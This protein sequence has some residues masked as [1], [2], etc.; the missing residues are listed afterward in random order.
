MQPGIDRRTLLRLGGYGV[1]SAAA[2]HVLAACGGGNGHRAAPRAIPPSTSEPRPATTVTDPSMPWWLRG[3]FGPVAREVEA[4]DLAVDGALPR[5]LSGLYVHNGSNP[6][7]G[8]SP[9]W[10][11]GDGMVH[12]VLLADGK[13]SWYRNRYVQTTLLAAGG[14]LTAKGAPGGAS[15]L[16]NVSLV[17]HAGKLLSL[18][19]VG[20]PYELRPR[21]LST[22]GVYDFDGKLEGN[23][24][25]HPKIDP[26]TQQMHFF[27]YNFTEPYLLY[28]VADRTGVLRSSEAVAVKASTMIHD[29]AI[30]DRDVVF[31]EMPVLFDFALAVKMVTEKRSRIIPYVWKPEYGSR[32]GVMPLGGPPSAIRWV[33]IDP[34]YVFHGMNAWRDGDEVVL[35]VSRLPNVFANGSTIG[36]S[37]RLHRWRVNTAGTHLTFRD[38]QRSDLDAELPSI[39]RRHTGRPYQHGWRVAALNQ[40][41]AVVLGGAIHTDARTGTETRWDPGPQFASGEWFFVP[42]GSGE[43]EGVVMSFVYDAARD[44]S[45]LV[46][47]DARDV[48]AGPLARVAL[49]QRVPHGFHATWVPTQEI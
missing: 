5:E 47:L 16:S 27:G 11:L 35:D 45:E 3:D 28:H 22:V 25:A 4:F 15:G 6:K 44:A 43:A 9:H 31:W 36:P 24:T 1:L 13:A 23:M 8:W 14:G 37:P 7:G 20:F 21:N 38:E 46:L 40:N 26:V 42:T 29:F 30:T 41:D 49:P 10:F 2:S 48:S 39:D 12:G 19:E 33:D 34:C 17:H 32:L 18:G